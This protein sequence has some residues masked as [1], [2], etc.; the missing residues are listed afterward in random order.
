MG[1]DLEDHALCFE[2]ADGVYYVMV[3]ESPT[4]AVETLRS[5]GFA[6]GRPRS[7]GRD[8]HDAGVY[9]MLVP[10]TL[11]WLAVV[12]QLIRRL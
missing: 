4:Q 3:T 2:T 12:S 6:P 10:A 9:V 1:N 8:V 11:L 5:L 7:G